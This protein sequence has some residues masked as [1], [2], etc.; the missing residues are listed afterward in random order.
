VHPRGKAANPHLRNSFR[1]SS[2]PFFLEKA[3]GY[4]L[5]LA[6]GQDVRSWFAL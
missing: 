3:V 6:S 2:G 5:S 4:G 1:L